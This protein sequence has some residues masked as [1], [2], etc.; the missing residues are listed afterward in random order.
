VAV[1]LTSE[2]SNLAVESFPDIICYNDK[3]LSLGDPVLLSVRPEKIHILREK[4]HLSAMHNLFDGI[5]DEIVYKGDHTHY[6]V[7]IGGKKISVIQQ[8]RR[9]LLDETPI[10][11]NEKVWIWWRADD[12]FILEREQQP[13][14]LEDLN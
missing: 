10:Q 13:H 4:P 14:P 5:V 12:G 11:W 8:H 7:L 1:S 2:Y 9:F 6:G 3:Q